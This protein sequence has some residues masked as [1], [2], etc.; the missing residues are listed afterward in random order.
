MVSGG[1]DINGDEKDSIEWLEASG[2]TLLNDPLPEPMANGFQINADYDSVYFSASNLRGIS[3]LLDGTDVTAKAEGDVRFRSS[4]ALVGTNQFLF[5][6]GDTRSLRT[7]VFDTNIAWGTTDFLRERRGAH[8]VTV[9]GL[10][11]RRLLVVGGFNIA[12]PGAPALADMEIVDALD[13]GPFGFPDVSTHYVENI[14]LPVPFAGHVGFLDLSGPTV[15][16]GGWGD[17][18]GPHSRRVVMILDNNSAPTV[19]CK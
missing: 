19:D 14:T 12:R 8:S 2:W 1:F 17:G 11:G 6:G 7:Y 16:A 5:L 13:P 10:G 3:G 9:R 15:V 18:V 4:Y